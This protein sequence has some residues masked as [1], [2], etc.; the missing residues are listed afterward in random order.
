MVSIRDSVCLA[1]AREGT[2]DRKVNV[3]SVSRLPSLPS[4]P[5]SSGKDRFQLMTTREG[6]DL[7]VVGRGL[8]AGMTCGA[9]P[10]LMVR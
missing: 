1:R 7:E 10:I 3:E 2:S 5:S 9:P 8:A 6:R 4:H